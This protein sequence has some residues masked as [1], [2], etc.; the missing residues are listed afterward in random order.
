LADLGGG[1]NEHC[2]GPRQIAGAAGSAEEKKSA[3][4]LQ[5]FLEEMLTKGY[6]SNTAI[7]AR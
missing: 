2:Q 7:S 6:G 3:A 5:K 1:S 4:R